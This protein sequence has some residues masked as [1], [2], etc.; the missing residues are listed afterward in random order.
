MRCLR[1]ILAVVVTA[2]TLGVPALPAAA[3]DDGVGFEDLAGLQTAM[4]RTYT[5]TTDFFAPPG[6]IGELR[7]A[8]RPE[9][10]LLL[11]A[12]YTFDSDASASA[13]LELL[14]TDMNATGVSGAPL[15]LT[16]IP[17]GLGIPHIAAMARDASVS[18]PVDFTLAMA[19]DGTLVYT[20]IA[21]TRG[22]P[23]KGAVSWLVQSVAGAAVSS[24]PATLRT[25]GASSGGAWAKVPTEQALAFR[26]RGVLEVGDAMP[27]SV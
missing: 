8:A 22:A 25:N 19:Q 10:M 18:P 15:P 24:E 1:L 16:E 13:G 2:L 7:D 3:Q 14:K 20:V 26:F 6:A 27:F 5:G 11:V 23:P 4:S 9:V 12:V 21:I 17:V